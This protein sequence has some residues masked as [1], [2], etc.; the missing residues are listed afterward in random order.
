VPILGLLFVIAMWEVSKHM[1]R[2]ARADYRA[3]R[4]KSLSAA[5]AK[6]KASA[7]QRA[8]N[9]TGHAA[10]WWAREA[11]QLFPVHR[12]GWEDGWRKHMTEHDHA[13]ARLDE[14]RATQ[15]EVSNSVN[16]GKP[17]RAR[18]LA[19]AKAH[20][21]EIA[22]RAAEAAA[23]REEGDELARKRAGKAE[24]PVPPLPA[25]TVKPAPETQNGHKAPAEGSEKAAPET[26]PPH[27]STTPPTP[28][29]GASPMSA[30]TAETTYQQVHE[31]T[32]ALQSRAD[33]RAAELDRGI[34]AA[35]Q[36]A[37][38]MQ[39][40]NVDPATIAAQMELADRL[41]EIQQAYVNAGEQA[42]SVQSSLVSTHEAGNEYHQ[43]TAGGGAERD[44]FAD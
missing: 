29:N 22:R 23:A 11:S 9:R 39:A 38:D 17:D 34:Q 2:H 7:P 19:D 20:K 37:D 27:D 25:E 31:Y 28:P 41:R 6:G 12:A 18:R 33:D 10:T 1:A 13:R 16:A 44:F 42:G 43:S 32:T 26:A 4:A 30:G 36:V 21:E 15:Q 35:I 24:A 5:A 40:A 8:G 14:A 3:S